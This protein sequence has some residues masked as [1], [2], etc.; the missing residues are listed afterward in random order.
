MPRKK[1]PPRVNGP[2]RESRGFRIR[3]FDGTGDHEDLFFAT[4]PEALQAKQEATQTLPKQLVTILVADAIAEYFADKLKHEK[5]RP[6]TAKEQRAQLTRFLD[7]ELSSP[8]SKLSQARAT[9]L[10]H[11]FVEAPT[12]KTGQPPKAAT[13]RFVLK[14][15]QSLYQ[16][17]VRRGYIGSNPFK[18]VQP[19]GRVSRGKP[20]LRFEEASRFITTGLRLY[21][22]Q[23]DLMA[24]ASVVA[25]LL[26]LRA[27]EVLNVCVRDLDC[28]GTKLWVAASDG[29]RG[30]TE[31]ARRDS[32]VP[33]VIQAR[34]VELAAR[35]APEDL[36]FGL[37][38]TG[39][40]RC[41][42]VLHR[43]VHR[44]CDAANVPRVCPHSLRGLW[45]TAGVRSGA[46]SHAVAEALG[47]GS[48][49]VTAKHYVKPGTIGDANTARLVETLDLAA[50]PKSDDVAR[51]SAE[52][53]LAKLPQDTLAELIKLATSPGKPRKPIAA[54]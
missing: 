19:V 26:G 3:I 33:V 38:E 16:W 13:H 21:D 50:A 42:Q 41:R 12:Q 1:S 25:L 9:S 44:V 48:F 7:A 43:A 11:S 27:S 17:A 51:L 6:E 40:P 31:N 14:L 20:Q 52:Q 30:K 18:D 37:G 54:A 4:E 29:Y 32:D 46:V 22:E 47:H 2:Y 53:L 10:Y 39:K 45:A 5:C 34:L 24:L 49:E 28:N 23:Q 35:H 36:L 8:L 15:A